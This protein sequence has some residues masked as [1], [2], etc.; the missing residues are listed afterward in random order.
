MILPINHTANWRLIC[1]L[2]QA[3]KDKEVIHENSTR[4]NHDYRIGDWFMVRLKNF[5]Y[6]TPFKGPYEILQI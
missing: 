6:E 5:E 1:Q 4:V 2:K 3:Q